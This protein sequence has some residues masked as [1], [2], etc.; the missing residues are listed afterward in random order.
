MLGRIV[1]DKLYTA[2]GTQDLEKNIFSTENA[3][4]WNYE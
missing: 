4:N 2:K 1:M 3:I